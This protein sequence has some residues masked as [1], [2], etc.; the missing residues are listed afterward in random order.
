MPSRPLATPAAKPITSSAD[1]LG[2]AHRTSSTAAEAS[3]STANRPRDRRGSGSA[4]GAR[5]RRRRRRPPACRRAAPLARSTLPSTPVARPPPGAITQIA[6]SEVPVAVALLVAEPQHSSGTMI[7]PPPTPNRP[8]NAPAAVPIAARRRSRCGHRAAYYGRVPSPRPTRWPRPLRP[9]T[10]A[11]AAPRSSATS[12]ARWRRSW[13]APRTRTCPR[14]RRACW[15]RWPAATGWSPASPGARR[16]E[17]RRLVGVGGDR[18]RGS[19]GAELLEPGRQRA[20]PSL[21]AFASWAGAGRR[22]SSA[23]RDDARAAPAARADR[24]QGADQ[25]VPLA[26]RARRGRGRAPASRASP[27][28]AEA[29]GLRHPLGPQG[30]GGPAARAGRQGPRRSR[31]LLRRAPA[32]APRCTAATTPPT[33]TPS[34]RWTALRGRG[35]AGRRACASASRSDEGPRADR[36]ARRPGRG[37][38]PGLRRGAG[39]PG[40]VEVRFRTSCARRC[41]CSAGAATALARRGDRGRATPTTT[42]PLL[43]IAV[44]WWVRG[45]AR[46]A[47][48][49]AAGGRDHAGIERLLADARDHAPRCPSSSRA[50]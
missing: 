26:R 10:E 19:H 33:S 17:A 48:G 4:A 13:S 16:A 37:R 46:R 21:P 31:E 47:C 36:R 50:R 7:V 49:S 20:R 40:R 34:T 43:Y 24:G 8:V 3:R 11:P 15:A 30:A 41:C 12:T 39:G 38:R 29:A 23:E 45:R 22:R 5:C 1:D 28:E 44:G 9:L 14:R 32:S 42:R 35:R 6:A 18:L 25:G 27:Q 2:L